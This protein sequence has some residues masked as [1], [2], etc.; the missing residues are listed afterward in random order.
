MLRIYLSGRNGT[1]LITIAICDD[2]ISVRMDLTEKLEQYS[3]EFGF[4]L[5]ILQFDDGRA[6]LENYKAEMDLIFLDIEMQDMDGVTAAKKIREM[7]ERVGIIFLTSYTKYALR[8][9]TVGAMNYIIK[10]IHYIRLKREME[11]FLE[12]RKN[13]PQEYIAVSNENGKFRVLLKDLKYIETDSGGVILHTS[14][15]EIP[16]NKSMKELEQLLPTETFQRCHTSFIVNMDY[17]DGAKKLEIQLLDG[18]VLP[19]SQPKRKSF[20]EALTKYW[21]NLL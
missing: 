15:K 4:K 6:L 21:G 13:E 10:P 2:E 1:I 9:Y 11:R 3:K 17:I 7:D 20:M 19:I 14:E 5:R 12:K 16:V 8:G 18:T